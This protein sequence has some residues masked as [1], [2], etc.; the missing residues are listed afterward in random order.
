MAVIHREKLT[1]AIGF[2]YNQ[3]LISQ[4]DIASCCQET[5]ITTTLNHT[6]IQIEQSTFWHCEGTVIQL[7][8]CTVEQRDVVCGQAT[9]VSKDY[10]VSNC[11]QSTVFDRQISCDI[12]I[13]A[14]LTFTGI[15]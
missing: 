5:A 10:L 8:N 9:A 13:F 3:G 6:A 14:D 15:G 12:Q 2:W 11:N 1:T 4:L 7:H